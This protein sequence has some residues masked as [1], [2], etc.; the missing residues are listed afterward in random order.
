MYSKIIVGFDGTDQGKDA[1]ALGKQLAGA[2]G[3]EVIL[4]GVFLLHPM[5]RGGGDPIAAEEERELAKQVDAAAGEAGVKSQN[6]GSTSVARG[7]HELAE[8]SGADLVVVG[9]STDGDHGHTHLGSTATSLLHGSPCAVAVAPT[10]YRDATPESVSTVV[11]GYDGSPESKSALE[12]ASE[13][14]RATGATLRLI[15]AA[16]PPPIVFGKSGGASGGWWAL[17]E[18]I[19]DEARTQLESAQSELPADVSA[20]TKVISDDPISALTQEAS[21]PGSILVLGSRGYGAVRGVMLGSVSRPIAMHTPAP[22]IVY[23]RGAHAE[24][25]GE[26]SAEAAVTA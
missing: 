21:A 13:L 9:S 19:E 11:V 6:V 2:T 22:V 10:G 1:L 25:H 7:L 23:P 18:G 17:K 16:E 8:K 15:A 24:E 5:M 26:A 14:A 4:S 12:S 20:E 3:A